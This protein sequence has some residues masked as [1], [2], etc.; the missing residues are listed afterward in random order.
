MGG[1]GY[2]YGFRSMGRNGY[3]DGFACVLHLLLRCH[4]VA[5]AA[6]F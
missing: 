6:E 2:D 4:E 3:R 5:E 1:N